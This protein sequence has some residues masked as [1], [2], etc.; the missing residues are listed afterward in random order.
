MTE[1]VALNVPVGQKSHLVIGAMGRE[2]VKRNLPAGHGS[3][4]I[5]P[6]PGSSGGV[7]DDPSGQMLHLVLPVISLYENDGHMSHSVRSPETSPRLPMGQGVQ[8]VAP[9]AEI[10]PASHRV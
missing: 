2:G 10:D 7:G 8:A 6:C 9:A 3:H 1:C 4:D 5:D